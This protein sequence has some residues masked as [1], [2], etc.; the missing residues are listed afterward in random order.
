MSKSTEN[1]STAVENKPETDVAQLEDCDMGPLFGNN[2][3]IGIRMR[4]VENKLRGIA[5]SD[6]ELKVRRLIPKPN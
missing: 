4:F 5:W 3:Q 6:Q 1:I 2:A